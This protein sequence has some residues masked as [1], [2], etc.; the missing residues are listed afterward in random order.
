MSK[1]HPRSVAGFAERHGISRATA[2]N[3][4]AR[5]HLKATKIGAR[6][7]ITEQ[8]EAEYL[9]LGAEKAAAAQKHNSAA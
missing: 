2:Y 5:G 3:E 7:I 4:I 1:P 8:Q 9:A 6:T